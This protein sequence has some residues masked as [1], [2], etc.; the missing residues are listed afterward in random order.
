MASRTRVF[1]LSVLS[2]TAL[3]AAALPASGAQAATTA[4]AG[5]TIQVDQTGKC[6]NVAGGST[7]N[8]AK[9]VQYQC[10]ASG[11]NDRWQLVPAGNYLYQV[12]GIQSGKCLTVSGGS[13]AN[14]A[15]L[16][17]YTCNTGSNEL[18]YVDEIFG[19]PTVRLVGSGS[20][21]CV[22]VPGGSTAN[23]VQLVQY[24]CTPNQTGPNERFYFPPTSSP[25]PVSRPLST[26]RPVSAV[27]GSAPAG[28]G[29]APVHFSWLDGDHNLNMLTDTAFDPAGGTQSPIWAGILGPYTGPTSVATLKDG[30]AQV[31]AHDA[32]TGD[33]YVTDEDAPG[34]GTHTY[35]DDIGGTS[36]G[37]PVVGLSN[38]VAGSL[39]VFSI[40]NGSL[41]AAPEQVN[42]A[43]AAVGAWRNLGGSGLVGTPVT[44]QTRIGT[45]VFAL[46]TAGQLQTATYTDNRTLSDWINLGG[47]GLTGTPAVA[48]MTGY[49][50]FVFSNTTS[51]T[52]V[53]KEQNLDASWPSDWHSIDGVTAVGNPTAVTQTWGGTATVAIRDSA[54]ALYYAAETGGATGVIGAWQTISGS[55]VTGSDP[56]LFAYQAPSG[57]SFAV[58]FMA[59]G[60]GSNDLPSYYAFQP[61]TIYPIVTPPASASAKSTVKTPAKKPAKKPTLHHLSGTKKKTVKPSSAR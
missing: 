41:W 54:G 40:V 5:I 3:V 38:P 26:E 61:N 7:A 18:W 31:V 13:I 30:R 49:M 46:N 25:A 17:T 57:Y 28:G 22:N 4:S 58:T 59:A 35:I 16:V 33:A 14:S 48:V 37:S 8:S 56:T 51:G 24:T 36:A 12:K 1:T 34:V 39:A 53:Y 47:T 29:E 9:V 45:N 60:A 32:A 55:G 43:Q 44:A 2:V 11:T 52:I 6:L 50:S 42:D 19:R 15:G 21:K 23:N 10:S 27:Q 20:G